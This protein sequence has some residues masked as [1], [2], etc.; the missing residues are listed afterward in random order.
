MLL[1]VYDY[2]FIGKSGLG[3]KDFLVKKQVEKKKQEV[4]QYSDFRQR[5]QA[6]MLQVQVQS[7]LKKS[8]MA[9]HQLDLNIGVSSPVVEW[10]WPEE[11]LNTDT[12]SEDR[13]DSE[14]I[15]ED[16]EEDDEVELPEV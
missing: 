11:F 3:R 8:K 10:Y 7:D 16:D 13:L 12:G 6:E 4:L 14:Y 2:Y 5:K 9:C 1:K 15:D